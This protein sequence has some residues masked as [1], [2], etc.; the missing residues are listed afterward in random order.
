MGA[1]GIEYLPS[2]H[3]RQVQN[4][5]SISMENV[6]DVINNRPPA[7]AAVLEFLETGS[8]SFIQ[9]NDLPIEN[10]ISLTQVLQRESNVAE[11]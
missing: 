5:P 11:L 3:Q 6:E 2:L 4:V 7:G 8:S 10:E 9:R 1:D